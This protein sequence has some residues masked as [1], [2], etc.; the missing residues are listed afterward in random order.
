MNYS[1]AAPTPSSSTDPTEFSTVL[2]AEYIS[3]YATTMFALALLA[4]G[5]RKT[6]CCP[7]SINPLL[8]ALAHFETWFAISVSFTMFNKFVFTYLNNGEFNLPFLVTSMHMTVK[9]FCMLIFTK[10][11]QKKALTWPN[12]NDILKFYV[13]I[14][15]LTGLDIAL[16]NLA[17]SYAAVTLVVV[18][19]T[20][21]IVFT[22]SISVCLGLEKCTRMLVAIV[23]VVAVGSFMALWKEPNF[24]L[25]GVLMASG[26]SLCGAL[27][28]TLTQYVSQK[29]K[30]SVPTLIL[31]T[32]P[33]GVVVTFICSLFIES[34]TVGRLTDG[35]FGP[36]A[37]PL[38]LMI[39]LFGGVITLALLIVEIS[40]VS[41]TSALA[42][43]VGA[44]V[45]DMCLIV[46]SMAVYGDQL[47]TINVVGFCIVSFGIVWYSVY[48]KYHTPTTETIKYSAVVWED[49]DVWEDSEEDEDRGD[50]LGFGGVRRGG[51][52]GGKRPPPLTNG[53]LELTTI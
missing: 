49:D 34:A 46:I 20:M 41:L 32:A 45:K 29:Q 24:V 6:R 14:G 33:S 42:T 23:T 9:F 2:M 13:P 36:T 25:M 4:L 53:D 35:T 37:V 1:T 15:I 40:L 50:F 18:T 52:V 38:L 51:G 43:D 11:I 39:G 47:S 26:S 17:V 22:L 5:V 31:F 48:K 8:H 12:W 19:K 7:S 30:A 3:I 10:C 27:R 16:V 44:K 28:W 21:G